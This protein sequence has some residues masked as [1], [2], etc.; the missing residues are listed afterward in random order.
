MFVRYCKD[1]GEEYGNSLFLWL[2]DKLWEQIGC[3]PEDFLCA[4]CTIDRLEKFRSYAYLIGGVG[5]HSIRRGN[6]KIM[7]EQNGA[8]QKTPV[9]PL[10]TLPTIAA[11]S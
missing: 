3:E 2:D 9:F 8:C 7:M 11:N 4:H 1:C 6:V 5:T 10:G